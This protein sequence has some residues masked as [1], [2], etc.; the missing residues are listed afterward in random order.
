MSRWHWRF[1]AAVVVVLG[2]CGGSGGSNGYTTPTSPTTPTTPTTPTGSTS[3]SITVADNSFSPNATTVAPGTSV[4]WSWSGA[5]PHNVVFDDGAK[6]DTQRSGTYART[7][8]TAGSYPYH[9]TIHGASM[10]G[11]VTVK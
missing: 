11:T 7:F 9:C 1:L 4:T 2:G 3:S 5:N 8:A 10:S 6:S